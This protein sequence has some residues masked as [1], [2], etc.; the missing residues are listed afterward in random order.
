MRAE[1]DQLQIESLSRGAIVP[2]LLT[3]GFSLTAGL[4]IPGPLHTVREQQKQ[5]FCQKQD[6]AYDTP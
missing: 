2:S 1:V 4:F 5:D 6:L 3:V